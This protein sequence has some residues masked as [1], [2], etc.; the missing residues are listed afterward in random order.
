MQTQ[1]EEEKLKSIPVCEAQSTESSPKRFLRTVTLN[2]LNFLP[3]DRISFPQSSF[4][5]DVSVVI[6]YTARCHHCFC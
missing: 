1:G 6:N 3:Q 4:N 2:A 5:E